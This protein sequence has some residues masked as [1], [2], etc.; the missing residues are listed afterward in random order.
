MRA[1]PSL[2]CGNA[3]TWWMYLALGE[4]P[5]PVPQN[6]DDFAAALLHQFEPVH[7]RDQARGLFYVLRQTA[8][9]HEYIST[10]RNL[11]M[12]LH[13]ISEEDKR[14]HFIHGLAD[15]LQSAI[16]SQAVVS[17]DD[18]IV[19]AERLDRYQNLQKTSGSST[20]QALQQQAPA[21]ANPY[22]SGTTTSQPRELR[23]L[24]RWDDY[25]LAERLRF[26]NADEHEQVTTILARPSTHLPRTGTAPPG[27][28]N[29]L[30]AGQRVQALE[31]D[32][33]YHGLST[34]HAALDYTMA[35]SKGI[36]VVD[37]PPRPRLPRG[38]PPPEPTLG[39]PPANQPGFW[40]TRRRVPLSP[41]AL[42][43]LG[44]KLR[45]T[46]ALST[47]PPLKDPNPEAEPPVR[48]VHQAPPFEAP[49]TRPLRHP[50]TLGHIRKDSLAD[51]HY[52]Q[53]LQ[54]PKSYQV[55]NDLLYTQPSMGL[56]Q[57]LPVA[58]GHT[59]T[60]DTEIDMVE[61]AYNS[62]H[63]ATSYSPSSLDYGRHPRLPFSQEH[64]TPDGGREA[65]ST[66]V[67]RVQQDW[68]ATAGRPE[69][70]RGRM[71]LRTNSHQRGRRFRSVWSWTPARVGGTAPST[72]ASSS[73][74]PPPRT[75][76]QQYGR[77]LRPRRG[78]PPPLP[79]QAL[80]HH[81]HRRRHQTHAAP[82]GY[83]RCSPQ[84]PSWPLPPP[85]NSS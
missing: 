25:S 62:V 39:L 82:S 55:A 24:E 23:I 33:G 59:A 41:Q 26:L 68:A 56:P 36:S 50:T 40:A 77:R 16:N 49:S 69:A 10:W 3:S 63:A 4:S 80:C 34:N 72:S 66:F 81:R 17:L 65:A 20:T 64:P 30:S 83:R 7:A 54:A 2:L 18:T 43:N 60:W 42:A 1:I 44:N 8:T 71:A 73:S 6:W 52:Q 35:S 47:S 70:S 46:V 21:T 67:N 78:P 15:H 38:A 12:H 48:N 13:D 79:R 28:G 31:H 57:P 45:A 19:N 37:D 9:V 85:F 51:P 74:M 14:F 5:V 61:P 11:A 22:T 53:L 75:S 76:S 84:N 27:P 29:V 58:D 32:H